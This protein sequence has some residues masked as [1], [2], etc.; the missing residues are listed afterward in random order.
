MI[1]LDAPDLT[2]RQRELVEAFVTAWEASSHAPFDLGDSP[3]EHPN[4]PAGVGL[5]DREEVRALFHQGLLEHD[6]SV[7]PAW[8]V[9]PSPKARELAGV[10]TEAA[11]RDPDRRLGLILEATVTAFEADPSQPLQFHP[12]DQVDLVRHPHW[13]LQPEVVRAHDLHQLEDLGLLAT[14]AA[15]KRGLTFWPTI[16]GR[17]AVKDAPGYLERVARET[18]DEREK[19]RLRRWAGHLRAGDVAVGTVAGSASGALIRA[20]MGL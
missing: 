19:T 18:E 17:A 9:F 11:L 15:G 4:W 13:P 14:T 16:Q 5:P 10:A 8:R 7:A 12:L 1:G 6:A 20:L 2:A 3:L